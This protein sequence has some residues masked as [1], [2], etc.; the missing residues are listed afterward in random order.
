MK[1]VWIGSGGNAQWNQPHSEWVR[2]RCV[3]NSETGKKLR[4][5]ALVS[6]R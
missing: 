1:D 5:T 2:G 6:V 3:G 4:G